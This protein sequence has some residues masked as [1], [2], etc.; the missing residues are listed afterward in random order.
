MVTG[1]KK[2]LAILLAAAMLL[3]FAACSSKGKDK[4]G[5]KLLRVGMECA[6][7]PYNWVQP[8]DANGAVPINNSKEYAYG[9]DVIMAKLLAEKAGYDGVEIHQIE[10]DNLPV[11]L[12]AGQVDCV[13]AGQSIT[14]KRLE[15]VDFTTPY[16]YA[17]I[18]VLTSKDSP[19][20]SAAGISG[21]G[22]ASC[23]SQLGTVWYEVCLPQIPDAKILTATE[24]AP[25]MLVALDSG[26]CDLVVTDKPTAKAA[27][28]AYPDL[29]TLDF[30]GKA[31]N[32]QV[33]DEEINIGI[34]VKKGNSELLNALNDALKDYTVADFEKMMNEAI[35]V[36]PMSNAD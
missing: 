3:A 12:N 31:D 24:S 28:I 6:Y 21:L 11:A 1:M 2:V 8:T 26:K 22:G 32:F 23:T 5:Q 14:A 18:V 35:A 27:V 34:S 7:A 15:T 36:Q 10:W 30:T 4:G 29:V 20:A 13:I 16:Y 17:S 9:Y 25:A 33:S 19:Y